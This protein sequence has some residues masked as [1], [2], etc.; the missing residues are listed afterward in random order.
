MTWTPANPA[1][2]IERV[3][4]ITKFR[5][6]IP[7]KLLR[8]MSERVASLQNE[9]RLAGPV[10]LNGINLAFQ[11]TPDGQPVFAEPTAPQSGWQ[12][13]RNSTSTE[14][15]EMIA[16]AGDQI[17][18]ETID[19]RRWAVFKQRFEKVAGPILHMATATLD[20]ETV[21]L[22]YFDRF[23]FVGPAEKAL[24]G[25]LLVGVDD[26]LHEDA[27]CGRTLWHVHRGWYENS[28]GGQVL[29]NQN[30]DANQSISKGGANVLVRSVSMLT[31]VDLRDG[32]F[33]VNDGAVVDRLDFMH[34]LSKY[35][36]K[37]AL[38]PNIR[39]IVGILEGN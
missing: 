9:T 37:S 23:T 7:T 8:Q 34:Q 15:I 6:N 36:F 28:E 13:S 24:P 32:M 30:F 35:Y 16:A 38:Q 1:H 10:P 5:A 17:I 12:F 25:E 21:S 14:A 20:V 3:R 26:N 27:K 2:A 22:E 29:I 18:Y 11:V 33:P 31:K 19:Y 4:F 39:K